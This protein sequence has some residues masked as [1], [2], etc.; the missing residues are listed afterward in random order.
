MCAPL[1]PAP[2][3]RRRSWWPAPPRPARASTSCAPLSMPPGTVPPGAAGV[4]GRLGLLAR[5]ELGPDEDG[6]VQLRLA[7]PVAAARGDRVVVRRPSPSATLAGGVIVD[8]QPVRHRRF[9]PRVLRH[10]EVL[11]A[12]APE[13]RVL[14]ALSTGSFQSV[15]EIAP[16]ADL[17]PDDARRTLQV[18]ATAG[19]VHRAGMLWCGTSYWND[20]V[21]RAREA[22]AA[23]HA[24]YPLR[25]GLPAEELRVRLRLSPEAWSA[26]AHAMEEEGA[27]RLLGE[28]VAL[29][30]H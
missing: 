14:D 2:A 7:G 5:P 10:L 22:L 11:G 16:R 29:A 4:A 30:E 27:V 21:V 26:A 1:W 24:R 8:A 13:D 28:G 12:G 15:D 19:R 17:P 20:L 6:W 18:L 25:R 3:W 23:H 9:S